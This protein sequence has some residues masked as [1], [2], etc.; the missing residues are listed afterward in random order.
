MINKTINL[1]Y[2]FNRF[3]KPVPPKNGISLWIPTN[4]LYTINHY[5]ELHK[6]IKIKTWSILVY[7][8]MCIVDLYSKILKIKFEIFCSNTFIL[9]H[10]TIVGTF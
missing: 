2:Q 9:Q 4:I 7:I 1:D 6:N 10:I 3:G 8:R 5:F